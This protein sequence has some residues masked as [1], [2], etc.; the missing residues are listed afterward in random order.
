MVLPAP[1]Q[2][3]ETHLALP[4]CTW[5]LI[6][7]GIRSAGARVGKGKKFGKGAGAGKGSLGEGASRGS[8]G[9]TF[10][11]TGLLPSPT[12]GFGKTEQAA[13]AW[14]DILQPTLLGTQSWGG[15]AGEES[16]TPGRAGPLLGLGAQ[17]PGPWGGG[18]WLCL[19]A[20]CFS[21]SVSTPSFPPPPLPG[22]QSRRLRA[23]LT[24]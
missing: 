20:V 8:G 21:F 18:S 16:T 13:K 2:D 22:H 1:L 9:G 24:P 4:T 6:E 12:G 11:L 23:D 10:I 17:G 3:C 14:L 5:E 19:S 15:R 7:M